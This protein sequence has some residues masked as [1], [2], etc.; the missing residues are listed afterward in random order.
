[1][2]QKAPSALQ[3]KEPKTKPDPAVPEDERFWRRYSPH[4]EFPLSSAASIAVHIL[5]I[6]LLILGGILA[7]KWGFGDS[8]KPIPLSIMDEPGGGGDPAGQPEATGGAGA[9]QPKDAATNDVKPDTVAQ[10]TTIPKEELNTPTADPL[11]LP[12]IEDPGIRWIDESNQALAGLAQLDKDARQKL[13]NSL[14]DRSRG[15]GGSGSGGGKGAGH[16]PGTGV[17]TGPG[18]GKLT[19]RQKRVLRWVIDF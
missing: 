11:S 13:F 16:G 15:Q 19:T 6:A 5:S 17:G 10:S 2:T 1:M 14:G 12:K 9:I 4:H 18:E 8:D 3:V 7:A